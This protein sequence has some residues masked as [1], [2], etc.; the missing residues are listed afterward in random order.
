MGP[1][2][3]TNHQ[4]QP[5]IARP[6]GG[7]GFPTAATQAFSPLPSATAVTVGVVDTGLVVDTEHRPHP[8]FQDHVAYREQDI[9]RIPD[10]G[11]HVHLGTADGHGTFVTGR[12]LVEAPRARVTMWGV[13]DKGTEGDALGADEDVLVADAVRQLAHDPNVQVI[14]L[15]F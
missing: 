8:W 15:S 12:I 7:V 1:A 4:V 6:P 10:R 11:A 5:L 14:N 9:D 2:M 13:L 3:N